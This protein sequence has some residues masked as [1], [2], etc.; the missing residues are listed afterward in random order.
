MRKV[1][2]FRFHAVLA[3]AM[4]SGLVSAGAQ[5]ATGAGAQAPPPAPGTKAAGQAV[6]APPAPAPQPSNPP[7]A[8]GPQVA[9]PQA[10]GTPAPG[11]QA[12]APQPAPGGSQAKSRV[13][14][15]TPPP[16]RFSPPILAI[17]A[18]DHDWGKAL[19]GES[20][21][22]SFKISNT[23]GAPLV[24]ERIKPSCGCTMVESPQKPIPPGGAD[25]FTLQI[26]TKSFSGKIKKTADVFSNAASSPDK[27]SMGGEV[28][29]LFSYEPKLPKLTTVRGVPPEPLKIS[30]SRSS[31]TYPVRVTEVKSKN[32]VLS[33]E[34]AEVEK[35]QLYEITVK[36]NLD[37]AARK[38]YYEQLDV[39]VE[40]GPKT[41]EIP[42]RVSVNVKE[43]IEVEP[44]NSIYFGRNETKTLESPGAPAL[45]KTLDIK[46]LGNEAHRFTITK[47]ENQG[48]NFETKLETVTEGKQYRLIVSLAKLPEGQQPRKTINDKLILRTDDATVPEITVTALAAL[49]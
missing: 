18:A 1:G 36:A 14:K 42:I 27:V 25:V 37:D 47:I 39:K 19:Q 6:Q 43:R 20:V 30:L 12:P 9:G 23:G 31:K 32:T 34:L 5:Q 2:L 41:M 11:S 45:T 48:G 46:S 44:R 29:P 35:D 15:L 24:I 21:K 16:A 28:E 49:N 10:P 26:D 38:Y 7:Q 33:A 4:L 40:S 17:E 22:H 8:P 3:A 13:F